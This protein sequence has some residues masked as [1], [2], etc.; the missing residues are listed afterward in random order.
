MRVIKNE[1]LEAFIRSIW[2]F[3]TIVTLILLVLTA[4]QISGTSIGIYHTFFYGNS[5]DSEL[6]FGHPESIRSDEW[7][8][9][10]QKTIAQKNNDFNPVNKNFGN[11]EDA[12]LLGELPYADWSIIFKPQNLGFF[13]LPFDNAFAL[14]W[15]LLSYFLILACYFFVLTIMPGRKRLAIVVS[16]GFFFSPFF[17][18]WYVPSALAT[19]YYAL[20]GTVAFIQLLESK[21]TLHSILWAL[22]LAYLGVGF[23]LMLYPPFQ[24][25]VGIVMVAFIIGYV[26]NNKK[27]F[28]RFHLKQKLLYTAGALILAVIIVGGFLYQRLG[29]VNALQNSVYPG[30]RV[31]KSGGFNLQHLLSSDLSPLFQSKTRA[32]NYIRPGATNAINQSESSNFILLFPFLL[33]PLYFFAY[34]SYKR[35]KKVDYILVALSVVLLLFL[36]WM[37]IPGLGFLGKI[38]L[39]DKVPLS[40]LV[41]GFGLLNLAFI[42]LFVK[43]YE[44]YKKAISLRTATLYSVGIFIFY[45]LLNSHI[46]SLFPLFVGYKL[47]V[48]FS[49]VFPIIVFLM[50]RKYFILGLSAL[51]LFSFVSVFMINPLYRGTEVLTETPLSQA[52]RSIDPSSSKKWISEDISLENFAAMNGRH[53]LT[54]VNLY[55]QLTLWDGLHQTDKR[56]DYNRYAHVNFTFTRT[57]DIEKPLLRTPNADQF[58]VKISPCDPFFK[59]NNVGYLITSVKFEAGINTCAQLLRE[60]SYPQATF[61]IYRL[62]F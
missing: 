56:D 60:V 32:D 54:G 9:G 52:I 48:I 38:S 55:P 36:S 47:V 6:I 51:A 24:I 53:S 42:L 40:R 28:K 58:N 45:L 50:L 15:W 33:A 30:H 27:A 12:A 46:S 10:T 34:K 26:I 11:G 3:P 59:Q 20:F 62:S 1:K 22:I 19:T 35:T 37:L 39:L 29:T 13:I 5:P 14:R 49:L 57:A 17:H 21:R 16:L 18:W 2:F 31:V 7:V 43:K 44:E 61:Y 23:T 8:V 41:V 25:P 4:L